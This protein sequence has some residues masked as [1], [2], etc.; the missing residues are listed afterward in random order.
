ML[1]GRQWEFKPAQLL[2]SFTL[3]SLSTLCSNYTGECDT[4]ISL[5]RRSRCSITHLRTALMR[6]P[7]EEMLG[8]LG[9]LPTVRVLEVVMDNLPSM[10][11][12]MKLFLSTPMQSPFI[13]PSLQHLKLLTRTMQGIPV[14]LKAMLEQFIHSRTEGLLS[15]DFDDRDSVKFQLL[16][17]VSLY[18]PTKLFTSRVFLHL[19][20]Q[21]GS[22]GSMNGVP[23]YY[24]PITWGIVATR[25]PSLIPDLE[26]VIPLI[27]IFVYIYLCHIFERFQYKARLEGFLDAIEG[28]HKYDPI[29]CDNVSAIIEAPDGPL[30]FLS[31]D[32]EPY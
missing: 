32:H 21:P 12:S 30:F 31:D 10:L 3:P 26:E 25:L 17:R 22:P 29:M 9:A 2:D 14:D 16:E 1:D 20:G 27:F 28:G 15:H 8:L 7:P 18:L 24:I 11:H 6:C 13:L 4:Y 23:Y 19:T 5:V